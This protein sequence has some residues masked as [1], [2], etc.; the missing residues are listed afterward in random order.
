MCR[1]RTATVFSGLCG[2]LLACPSGERPLDQRQGAG[3]GIPRDTT[4]TGSRDTAV[5]ASDSGQ[6]G[7]LSLGALWTALERQGDSLAIVEHCFGGVPSLTLALDS[8]P[9]RVHRTYGQDAEVFEIGGWQADDTLL[10]LEI[11]S[12]SYPGPGALQLVVRDRRRGAVEVTQE[13]GGQGRPSGLFVSARYA[14]PWLLRHQQRLDPLVHSGEVSQVGE[15]TL[16]W[17][18]PYLPPFQCRKRAAS[19]WS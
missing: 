11:R 6:R 16:S 10:R 2:T 19:S 4:A 9:P 17:A 5:A 14:A 7:V 18:S 3:P 13:I 15:R 12:R 8:T 1:I